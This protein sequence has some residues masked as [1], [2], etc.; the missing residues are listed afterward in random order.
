M[1][2]RTLEL[3]STWMPV[4]VQ[5]PQGVTYVRVYAQ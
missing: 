3:P 1:I 5:R 4:Y 2:D